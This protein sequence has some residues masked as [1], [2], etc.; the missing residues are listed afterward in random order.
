M[1]TWNFRR[2][3]GMLRLQ[4][5]WPWYAMLYFNALYCTNVIAKYQLSACVP[6]HIEN[7]ANMA[8]SCHLSSLIES[9][10]RISV[11]LHPNSYDLAWGMIARWDRYWE[12][13]PQWLDLYRPSWL[14]AP[15]WL[16][17]VYKCSK[18]MWIFIF[19][20]I[21][22]IIISDRLP[23]PYWGFPSTRLY[24]PWSCEDL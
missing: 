22:I 2:L 5:E 9:P 20:F 11:H 16:K 6:C 17:S 3:N 23:G 24:H 8:F 15:Q 21:I 14:V 19:I 18:V 10:V 13:S 12:C 4:E 1:S 7:R